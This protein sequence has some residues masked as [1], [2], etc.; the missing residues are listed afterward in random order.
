MSH[1]QAQQQMDAV[2]IQASG[3]PAQSLVYRLEPVPQPALG[4]V[5]VE[6]HAAAVNPLDIANILGLLGTPLP[7]IPGGDFAGI[8]VSD[9]DHAGQEVWGSGPAL[10]MALGVKRRGTHARYVAIPETWLSRKPERLTMAE[11]A[12][13]GR[14]HW[15]AWETLINMMKITPGET[16]LI[17][18][19]AGMVGQA[20]TAIARWRGAEVII[21]DRRRADTGEQ[22]IDTSSSDIREE[23]LA[24][25][26]GRGADLVLDTVGGALF[27]PALRSLR[28]DGR[29]VGLHGGPEPI[30]LD[31]SEI[32]NR[33][34]HVTGLASVFTDGAH[35]ARI[36]DQLR[37]LFD[38]RILAPPTVKTWPLENSAEAYQTVLDGSGGIKQVLLPIN[39]RA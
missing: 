32:Y 24:L 1:S 35:V 28:F 6:V 27:G 26:G 17:T 10:G 37:A 7:M 36:F 22:F 15:A 25:T 30:E 19:G 31:L 18:G 13:V 38:R 29:L 16:I 23:V 8:V 5:L 12:A 33:Q 20:A 11:A 14:S 2:V 34:L 3:P 21:A 9:G 39:G 4:E